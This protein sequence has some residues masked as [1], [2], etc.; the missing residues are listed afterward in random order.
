MGKLNAVVQKVGSRA[1]VKNRLYNYQSLKKNFYHVRCAWKLEQSVV[2]VDEMCEQ[3]LE[4]YEMFLYFK[5]HGNVQDPPKIFL[6]KIYNLKEMNVHKISTVEKEITN[7]NYSGY[8]IWI[9]LKK[10]QKLSFWKPQIL[11]IP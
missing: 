5:H 3:L 11:S 10:N 2:L 1:K 8:W 9:S 4:T 6:F 7:S